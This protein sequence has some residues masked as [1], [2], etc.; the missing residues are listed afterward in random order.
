MFALSLDTAVS[1]FRI[2]HSL[3]CIWTMDPIIGYLDAAGMSSN[4]SFAKLS[5]S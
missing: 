4:L 3:D 2:R 5:Q 1:L